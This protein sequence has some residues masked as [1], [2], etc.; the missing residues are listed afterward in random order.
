MTFHFTSSIIP[1]SWCRGREMGGFNGSLPSAAALQVCMSANRKATAR[2][3]GISA[4]PPFSSSGLGGWAK[5]GVDILPSIR[6]GAF[7]VNTS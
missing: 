2:K 5:C 1:F 7:G 4:L 3:L 6:D